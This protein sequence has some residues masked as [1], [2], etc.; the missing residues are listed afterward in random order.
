VNYDGMPT[1][2]EFENNAAQINSVRTTVGAYFDQKPISIPSDQSTKQPSST[3]SSEPSTS[4]TPSTMPSENLSS[5]PSSKPSDQPPKQPSSTP[6][7]TVIFTDGFESG[8]VTFNDGGANSRLVGGNNFHTGAKS[9]RLQDDTDTSLSY[10]NPFTVSSY[11]TLK[12]EFWYKSRGF[13]K[14]SDSFSLQ[15]ANGD[16]GPDWATQE[17]WTRGS[18]GFTENNSWNFVS[19]EFPIN[20]ITMRIRFINHANSNKEKVFIDDVAVSGN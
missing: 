15:A 6:I 18:N 13:D 17:T 12:V 16:T 3:P 7:W 10:T 8:Y 2:T 1:G 4:V 5:E 14:N 9:L 11:S 20:T 19:V